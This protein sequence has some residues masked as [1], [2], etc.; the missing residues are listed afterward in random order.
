MQWAI[1]V[2]HLSARLRLKADQ[3]SPGLYDYTSSKTNAVLSTAISRLVTFYISYI[4]SLSHAKRI[5]QMP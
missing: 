4:L 5:L 1:A 2:G 3:G